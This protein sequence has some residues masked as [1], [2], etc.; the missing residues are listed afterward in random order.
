MFR[1]ASYNGNGPCSYVKEVFL[2]DNPL[3]RR[4][5]KHAEIKK[6]SKND[7]IVK[8]P[9]LSNNFIHSTHTIL[10]LLSALAFLY[11][12]VGNYQPNSLL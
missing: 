11:Q 3:N 12:L 7:S 5:I 4:W 9:K 8:L 6:N 2:N 1:V 10:Y